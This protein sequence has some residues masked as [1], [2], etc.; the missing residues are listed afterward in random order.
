MFFLHKTKNFYLVNY[1][2]STV[3][4]A[5]LS[6]ASISLASAVGTFSLIVLGA[7][8]TR[9]FASLSPRPVISLT[10]FITAILFAPASLRATVNS[11]FSSAA[12]G[13]APATGAPA[14]ATGAAA[15]TPNSSSRAFTRSLTST[16]VSFLISS[17]LL[18]F[19]NCF[20]S[21]CKSLNGSIENSS[22]PTD[23]AH[24]T[25]KKFR[26]K[27]FFAWKFCKS[28]NFLAFNVLTIK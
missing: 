13:A 9:A 19:S 4:P 27:H 3:A 20:K 8:S 12:A 7:L 11:L 15:L 22:K 17:Y 26:N 28:F 10:T 14:T 2:S 6:L 23:R 1:L 25:P 5:S 24:K 21:N 18:F 16:L